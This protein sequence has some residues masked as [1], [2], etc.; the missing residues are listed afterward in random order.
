MV[1]TGFIYYLSSCLEPKKKTLRPHE[2]ITINCFISKERMK[3]IKDGQLKL[4][5]R[6]IAV[7][8]Q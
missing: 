1:A 8:I 5:I 4:N 7:G 3:R 2:T 6:D